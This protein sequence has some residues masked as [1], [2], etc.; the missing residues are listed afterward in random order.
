VLKKKKGRKRE[1]EGGRTRE[2]KTLAADLHLAQVLSSCAHTGEQSQQGQTRLS[3]KTNPK[4]KQLRKKSRS[5]MIG[6]TTP[7]SRPHTGKND[8]VYPAVSFFPSCDHNNV[9]NNAITGARARHSR[10]LFLLVT[11]ET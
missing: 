6:V 9:V 11:C 10:W 1:N 7:E 2:R 3:K 4:K 5:T 8:G